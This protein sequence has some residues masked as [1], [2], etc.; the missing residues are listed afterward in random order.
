VG[1]I[2][3]AERGNAP[4]V[5]QIHGGKRGQYVPSAFKVRSNNQNNA[6]KNHQSAGRF[7]MKGDA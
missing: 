4:S 6:T 2:R 7:Y 3:A 1:G 5:F